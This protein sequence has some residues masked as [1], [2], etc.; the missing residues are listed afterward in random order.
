MEGPVFVGG[1]L[2]R[3]E[4]TSKYVHRV[5]CGGREGSQSQSKADIAHKFNPLS[6]AHTLLSV[7]LHTWSRGSSQPAEPTVLLSHSDTVSH[8]IDHG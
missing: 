3:N 1:S 2:P 4:N 7:L 6:P 5:L 8:I